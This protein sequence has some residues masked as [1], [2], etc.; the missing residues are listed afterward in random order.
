MQQILCFVRDFLGEKKMINDK[1]RERYLFDWK[2]RKYIILI[3]LQ[4]NLID[5]GMN[6]FYTFSEFASG[7]TKSVSIQP[8]FNSS[9]SP[10]SRDNK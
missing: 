8:Q 7:A 6:K 1:E 3:D 9:T 5:G 4:I 2:S 10:A